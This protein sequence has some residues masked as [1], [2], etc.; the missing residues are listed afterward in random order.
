MVLSGNAH[1]A[2]AGLCSGNVNG[3]HGPAMVLCHLQQLHMGLG[4]QV[5]T[6]DLS[7][8]ACELLWFQAIDDLAA[9]C[10]VPAATSSSN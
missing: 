1:T 5:L 9:A 7:E 10:T 3:I 6:Q 2:K 8:A 4:R